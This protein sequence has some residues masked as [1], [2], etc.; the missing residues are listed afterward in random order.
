MYIIQNNTKSY[1]KVI[2]TSYHNNINTNIHIDINDL[3][4]MNLGST[5]KCLSFVCSTVVIYYIF[6]LD[7]N[8][9]LPIFYGKYWEVSDIND[10]LPMKMGITGKCLYCVFITFSI[11]SCKTHY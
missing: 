7:T 1:I 5:G 9:L 3:L 2:L 6:L 8:N 10:L 11:S 4:P